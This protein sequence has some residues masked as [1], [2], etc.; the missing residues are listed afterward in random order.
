MNEH[1]TLVLPSRCVLTCWV[2]SG[3]TLI[4]LCGL[5]LG[6]R[7]EHPWRLGCLDRCTR[8][9]ADGSHLTLG[10][11]TGKVRE[12]LRDLETRVEK[13]STGQPVA[14]GQNLSWAVPL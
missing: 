8:G 4:F 5:M 12:P 2:V 11:G 14:N 7:A 3:H 13:G 6:D 9:T 1:G 10:P